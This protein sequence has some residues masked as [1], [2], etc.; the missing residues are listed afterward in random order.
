MYGSVCASLTRATEA[1]AQATEVVKAFFEQKSPS[2]FVKASDVLADV[3][4]AYDEALEV[5]AAYARS[6][7]DIDAEQWKKHEEA[8]VRLVD[9][10]EEDAASS[11]DSELADPA[12]VASANPVESKEEPKTPPPAP[13]KKRQPSER[14]KATPV[15]KDDIKALQKRVKEME[16]EAKAAKKQAEKASRKTK[17][18]EASKSTDTDAA[19]DQE[20]KKRR[21]RSTADVEKMVASA[22]PDLR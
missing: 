14:K 9:E 12:S 13:K 20:P 16:R 15:T 8:I 3:I 6:L 11:S 2:S 1:A 22:M 7:V 10:N 21:R 18:A 5:V 4:E 19:A 17:K